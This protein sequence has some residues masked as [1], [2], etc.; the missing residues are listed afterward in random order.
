M[1]DRNRFVFKQSCSEGDV[2]V[3]GNEFSGNMAFFNHKWIAVARWFLSFVAGTIPLIMTWVVATSFKA[4]LK[5][6]T[7]LANMTHSLR[8]WTYLIIEL[9][10][11]ICFVCFL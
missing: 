4:V 2:S 7:M 5:P 11:L 6:G 8:L 9:V 1:D 3:Q 10:I